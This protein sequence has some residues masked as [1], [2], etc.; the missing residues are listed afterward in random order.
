MIFISGFSRKIECFFFN[1]F[2]KKKAKFSN[3]ELVVKDYVDK[4]TVDLGKKLHFSLCSNKRHLVFLDFLISAALH[5]ILGAALILK[6]NL[7]VRRL[8]EGGA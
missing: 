1:E 6:K 3:L 4:T 2:I 8:L 7:L 5:W